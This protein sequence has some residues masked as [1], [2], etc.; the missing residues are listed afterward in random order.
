MSIKK[1]A[2]LQS[3]TGNNR[4]IKKHYPVLKTL[5]ESKYSSLPYYAIEQVNKIIDVNIE[6]NGYSYII[7]ATAHIGMDT[8]NFVN[9]FGVKCISLEINKEA[10]EALCYN[11]SK[12]GL[13]DSVKAININYI[14]FINSFKRYVDLI[15]FDPPWGGPS[16]WKKKK[17]MLYLE[18]DKKKIPIY[19]IINK[20]FEKK[21]TGKALLKTPSNF[22]IVTFSKKFNGKFTSHKVMK[23][24]KQG[25]KYAHISYYLLVCY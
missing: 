13:Q 4:K 23:P 3:S 24:I 1:H 5:E 17:M 25:K 6:L 7:D 8:F 20:V 22:D 10:Y 18:H 19:D 15:Y 9:S 12:L 14:D 11:I 21:A 2:L 16:Y